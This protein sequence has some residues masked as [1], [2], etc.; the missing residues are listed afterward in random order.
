MVARRESQTAVTLQEIAA[1]ADVAVSTVSRALANPER[2]SRATR[3]HV[4]NVARRLGY[5]HPRSHAGGDLLCLLVSDI[6]N[7]HNASL[8][9]G[10]EAQARAAGWSLVVGATTDGAE[11]ELAQVQRLATTVRGFLLA[12]SRLSDAELHSISERSPVGSDQA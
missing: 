5:S 7:P 1:E 9:R 12:P 3:E 2:V 10:A 6:G 4:Q 8:I 11:V